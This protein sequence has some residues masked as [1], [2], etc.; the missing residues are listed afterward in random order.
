MD[1]PAEPS[2]AP[3]HVVKDSIRALIR[4]SDQ[5]IVGRLHA[6]PQKRFKDEMNLMAD[7]YL[8]VTDVRVFDSS[9]E[10]FLYEAS[11]LLLANAHIVSLTP[12]NA[13]RGVGTGVWAKGLALPAE[14][15]APAP[16]A[17]VNALR[18]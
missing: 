10:I 14:Q 5:F 17:P 16:D 7:R 11:F 4:T 2:R 6:R 12:V 1:L 13:L 18:D 15:E 8:A 9:G 3:S